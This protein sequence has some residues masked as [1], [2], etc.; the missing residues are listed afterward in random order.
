MKNKILKI[1]TAILTLCAGV[2]LSPV[3]ASATESDGD[4]ITI[5]PGSVYDNKESGQLEYCPKADEF[6]TEVTSGVLTIKGWNK[7]SDIPNYT[8][9]MLPG[10]YTI[11]STKYEPVYSVE[12]LRSIGADGKGVVFQP[13]ATANLEDG[14]QLTYVRFDEDSKLNNIGHTFRDWDKLVRVDGFANVVEPTTGSDIIDLGD[15]FRGCKELTEIT[16]DFDGKDANKINIGNTFT[17]CDKLSKIVIKNAEITKIYQMAVR[18]EDGRSKLNGVM[19]V[20][21]DITFENITFP[22]NNGDAYLSEAFQTVSGKITFKNCKSGK[23][24]QESNLITFD[25]AFYN[26]L[27]IK[28]DKTLDIAEYVTKA[29]T[30]SYLGGNIE[31]T[32]AGAY[33]TR[34]MFE[35]SS[36]GIIKLNNLITADTTDAESMFQNASLV[37]LTGLNT[38][39]FSGTIPRRNVSSILTVLTEMLSATISSSPFG[40]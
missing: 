7:P 32:G 2:M 16:L 11:G 27:A 24:A 1:T 19:A 17:G 25:K 13:G 31:I 14:L 6:V 10:S 29:N 33:S 38:W 4:V 26:S 39:K 35:Q 18:S 30:A 8:A 15:T 40:I 9:V 21:M 23:G 36:Y 12:I 5:S 22:E 34:N 28:I 20:P 37:N 3:S